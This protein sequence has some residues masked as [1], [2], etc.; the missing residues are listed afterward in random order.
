MINQINCYLKLFARSDIKRIFRLAYFA[1]MN[2][3][4]FT[5]L[6]CLTLQLKKKYYTFILQSYLFIWTQNLYTLL[7][8]Y[9]MRQ[10]R[11][12]KSKI[13]KLKVEAQMATS[14]L[15]KFNLIFLIDWFIG[16]FAFI[17]IFIQFEILIE[18]KFLR[19]MP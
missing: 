4:G 16:W 15:A 10:N 1:K 12:V 5:L 7:F 9:Y 3:L 6:H 14:F 11:K 17:Y 2:L 19:K 8:S 18:F 13:F